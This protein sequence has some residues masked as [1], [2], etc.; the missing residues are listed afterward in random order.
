MVLLLLDM[1]KL[2]SVLHTLRYFPTYDTYIL[3][4]LKPRSLTAAAPQNI[5]EKEQRKH[6][7]RQTQTMSR[8]FDSTAEHVRALVS[9][10]VELLSTM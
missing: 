10:F 4:I 3:V 2:C 6:E 9:E 5:T 8:K 7:K 1:L